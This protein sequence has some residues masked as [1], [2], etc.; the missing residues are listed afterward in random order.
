[1]DKKKCPFKNEECNEECALFIKVNSS[2][3]ESKGYCS[4]YAIAIQLGLLINSFTFSL[5]HPGNV[6]NS[7][8]SGIIRPV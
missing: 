1:M 6:D 3:T 8:D 7:N 4:F 2:Q 5:I